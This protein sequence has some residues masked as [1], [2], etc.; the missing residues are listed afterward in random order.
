MNLSGEQYEKLQEALIDAFPNKSSLEQMLLFKLDKN[1]TEIV[2]DSNLKVI[3]FRLI[4]QAKSEGWLKK[5]VD[6]AHISNPGNPRLKAIAQEL[7]KESNTSADIKIQQNK[8]NL[9]EL[10]KNGIL[11]ELAISFKDEDMAD[12][13]LN[14]IDFPGHMRPIFPQTGTVLGY[15]QKICLQIQNGA[16]PS[17]NDLQ[18][19]VDAAA[20]IFPGNPVFQRYRS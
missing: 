13:L 5:L 15:W 16:S 11:N 4:Q 3:V 9:K 6:A 19:L 7:A 18:S 17:G 10:I 1:L 8:M 12:V 14:M 20:D 2:E